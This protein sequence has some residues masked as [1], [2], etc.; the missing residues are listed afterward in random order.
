[1]DYWSCEIWAYFRAS[2]N[3]RA[4]NILSIWYSW[5][6]EKFGSSQTM[7]DFKSSKYLKICYKLKLDPFFFIIHFQKKLY[8]KG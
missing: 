8:S 4:I 2:S 3:V 5:A 7:D 6:I 1:M